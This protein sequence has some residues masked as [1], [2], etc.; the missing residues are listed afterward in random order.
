M[1]YEN[2]FL[3]LRNGKDKISYDSLIDKLEKKNLSSNNKLLQIFNFFDKDGNGVLEIKNANGVNEMQSLWN[4]VKSSASK[5]NNSI[6]EDSEAQELLTNLIDSTGKSL[7]DNKISSTDLFGFLKALVNQP[8]VQA[9]QTHILK[10]QQSKE[11]ACQI[12]D[13]NMRDAFEIFNSQHLGAVTEAYDNA[14]DAD[15]ALKSTN[16]FKIL[17][18]QQAGL[19]QLIE[20]KNKNLTKREYYEENK[21][22]IKDMILT[23]LNVLKTASGVS[24]IDSFRGEYS[25]EKMTEF[26][27]NYVEKICSDASMEDL[28]KIQQQFVSYN[29]VE[30]TEALSNLVKSAKDYNENWKDTTIKPLGAEGKSI[31]LK[32]PDKGIVPSYWDSDEP[33]SFEEVYKLERGTEFSQQQVEKYVQAKTEMET[34]INAYN[35][36]QQFIEFTNALRDEKLTLT[37]KEEKLLTGFAEFY[38]LSEDGGLSQLQKVIDNS[39]LPVTIENGKLNL[40]KFP[41]EAS[42]IDAIN[43]L[44]KIA[45]SEKENEFKAFLGDKTIEEYQL[46]FEKTANDVLGKENGKLLAD[47]MVNDNMGM[48]KRYTGNSSMAGM[49]LTVVGGV[50]CFTPLAPL[51]A[52]LVTAGNTLA[53]GGMVAKTGL[54]VA[55]LVT[56][57]VQTQEELE[58]LTKDFVMD[59]GGFIIGMKAGQAGVKAFNKLIDQKLVAVFGEQISQGNKMQAL[60]TIF[61]NPEY[62]ENFSKAAG[63]KISTDFL[64]SYMG[65]LAMMG[66]LDTQDDWKSLLQANLTGILVGMSGDIKNVAGVK[67]VKITSDNIKI[68][69][70]IYDAKYA[71]PPYNKLTAAQ[72]KVIKYIDMQ[73][74]KGIDENVTNAIIDRIDNSAPPNLFKYLEKL[75]SPEDLAKF[76]ADHT[77]QETTQIRNKNLEMET[78][79]YDMVEIDGKTWCAPEVAKSQ[80]ENILALKRFLDTQSTPETINVTRTEGVDVMNSIKIGD[81]TIAELMNEIGSDGDPKELLKILNNGETVVTYDNFVGTSLLTKEQRFPNSSKNINNGNVALFWDITVPKGAKGAFIENLTSENIMSEME[82]LLQAG[83]QLKITGAEFKDGVWHLKG[84]LVGVKNAKNSNLTNKP[85]GLTTEEEALIQKAKTEN[86][87]EVVADKVKQQWTQ[88]DLQTRVEEEPVDLFNLDPKADLRKSAPEVNDEVT[89]LIFTGKLKERLTQRYNDMG[90]VLE[91]IAQERSADIKKLAKDCGSDKKQFTEGVV[92]ILAEEMGLKG[93]EPKIEFAEMEGTDGLAD[94]TT[95]TIQI[96]K[97]TN[98]AKKIV[99]ILSHEFTHMLQY[100]DILAQ[101][102]EQGL[103][104]VIMNDKEIAAKDKDAEIKK[105]L[106]SPFTARLLENY[107]ALKHSEVGALNEYITRIYKDEFANPINPNLDMKGYVDQASE[108]E[109]YRFGSEQFG[110]NVEGVEQDWL[111]ADEKTN[112]P[113]KLGTTKNGAKY[114]IDEYGQIHRNLPAGIVSDLASRFNEMLGVKSTDLNKYRRSSSFELTARNTRISDAQVDK[115]YKEVLRTY[116]AMYD[117]KELAREYAKDYLDDIKNTLAKD[118][119]LREHFAWMQEHPELFGDVSVRNIRDGWN[120]Y[121][122]KDQHTSPWKMHLFS[123]SEMDWRTM[124]EVVIPYLK[125]QGVNWKT[126]DEIQPVSELEGS[127]KGKAFTIYPKNNEEMAKIAK[128]LDYIIRNNNLVRNDSNIEGDRQ[129]GSTGRLFYRY[130]WNS[131]QY[132]DEILDLSKESDSRK[133]YSRYDSNRGIDPVTGESKYLADDMTPADD[134]WLNFDPAAGNSK[135]KPQSTNNQTSHIQLQPNQRYEIKEFPI[136]KMTDYELDLNQPRIKQALQGLVE[137][138][139]VTVGREGNITIPEEHTSVSRQHVIIEKRNGKLYIIDNNST[140]GTSIIESNYQGGKPQQPSKNYNL[141]NII[142]SSISNTPKHIIEKRLNIR[143]Y[144]EQNFPDEFNRIM[145]K[146]GDNNAWKIKWEDIIQNNST[147]EQDRATLNRLFN[148]LF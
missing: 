54:G 1:S 84:E 59:A 44:L 37:E 75:N 6:F 144:L 38:S 79:T 46:S 131:G 40:S 101:Y 110:N 39:K 139:Q 3:Y 22:R 10:E 31:T 114:R 108:R 23:R 121:H 56:K 16:V 45:G 135:V 20:A 21:Q 77:V 86:P 136:L 103:R 55:D 5:N 130:E 13:E 148:D 62:L 85:Q 127:Q 91:E 93:F 120:E 94:W 82:F 14:K 142:D 26:I 87:A 134:I 118:P 66:A 78:T 8:T 58:E 116:K 132:K 117:N 97:N 15:D 24:Y 51:G 43:Q 29:Q 18:Y 73:K 64:I 106:E 50:L 25:K 100:R 74:R 123:D 124:S 141:N 67:D 145:V 11:V 33:I 95:G 122:S 140:N 102:G 129:M 32:E 105:V 35:K 125:E 41:D 119:E 4:A 81:K 80:I 115:M 71:M 30:E 53:I 99:E 89:S 61:A 52:G 27:N 12:I 83:S 42:K 72:L 47:A 65:D 63:A 138:Q 113:E 28:K 96:N 146:V 49:G 68:G 147:L 128:D 90:K 88:A 17:N 133:C 36:K 48:I 92:K 34:V 70:S 104:E 126:A 57:D 112:V 69:T 109:A 9:N 137:G 111:I 98:N 60:K 7:A 2:N 76:I 107:N 143:S 19:K